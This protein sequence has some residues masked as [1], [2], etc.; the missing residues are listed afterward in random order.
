[1]DSTLYYGGLVVGGVN[2]CNQAG[3]HVGAIS[4]LAMGNLNHMG[5]EVPYRS[6][7]AGLADIQRKPSFGGLQ[8]MK[9]ATMR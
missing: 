9:R 2:V 4:L 3:A 7:K 5:T 1:M 8:C 6:W